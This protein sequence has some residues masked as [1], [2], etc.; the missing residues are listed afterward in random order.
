MCL[1][2]AAVT[3]AE[4][5]EFTRAAYLLEDL[6]M[7]CIDSP[8]VWCKIK[9]VK[10]SE[11]LLGDNWLIN[12][13]L[14]KKPNDPDAFR[15]LGEVK[16]QLRDYE[17]SVAAYKRSTMV[18]MPELWVKLWSLIYLF[19]KRLSTFYVLNTSLALLKEIYLYLHWKCCKKN[20]VSFS[21]FFSLG[22]TSPMIHPTWYLM[23]YKLI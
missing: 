1:Q 7:V 20:I 12:L 3:L 19:A 18:G 21:L 23:S 11:A 4:L 13:D 10:L 6:I 16:Y 15:L 8:C 22:K 14:Q 2:G 5:G 9:K 17:G